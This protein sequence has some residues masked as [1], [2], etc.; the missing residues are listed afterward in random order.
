MNRKQY[1]GI[2]IAA[3]I[4]SGAQGYASPTIAIAAP[5]ITFDGADDAFGIPGLDATLNDYFLPTSDGGIAFQDS[6]DQLETDANTELANYGDQE[7]LAMGFGNANAYAAQSATL[8]G[9]QGYKTFAVMGGLIVGA[10]MPS[11]DLAVLQAIP[12]TIADDPDIYAGIAPSASL[13]IGINA[14]KVFGF[15]NKDLGS[16]M[17]NIYLNVKFGT[18]DYVYATDAQG[19]LDMSS[20]NFG[21]GVNYQW[22]P[23]QKSFLFGLAKWRGISLG[24]GFNYQSNS[25]K[26][27]TTIDPIPTPFSV[28][29]SGTGGIPGGSTVS[30]TVTAVPEIN[31]GIEMQTYSIPLEA[32]TSVQLFWLLNLNL[33]AGMDLV[34]GNTDI[35]ATA[36]SD[37]SISDTTTTAG[38]SP[39][40]VTI[41][42]TPGTFTLEAGTD[43][44]APS[45]A[46]GR[47][48]TGIGLQLGPVK[49]DI[50]VYYYFMSGMAFGL[51]AGIVW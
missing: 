39:V 17:K 23:S 15:F 31:L 43:G 30:G 9:Y 44:I 13:N 1:F 29:V 26:F 25:I 21:V 33:G 38:G 42:S 11:I 18:L 16:N 3:I 2:A 12:D 28:D 10:Q 50:P 32:S 6:I 46:R 8:Q 37:V 41:N 20:T 22:I 7:S 47:L 27:S 45:I 34:F 49:I 48:M 4:F 35:T 5:T 14:G 51:T 40:P 36:S 19:D 24:S